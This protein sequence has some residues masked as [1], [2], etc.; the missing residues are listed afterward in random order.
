MTLK[1]YGY[2]GCTTVNRAVAWAKNAG[3]DPDYSHFAKVN[4]LKDHI[5]SWIEIAGI[6]AVFNEKAQTFKKMDAAE[7][8]AITQSTQTRIAAM[9]AE[10]RLIKR[11]VGTDGRS[12]LTG[13]SEDQWSSVF[14]K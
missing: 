7:R 10:P 11:P 13:F 8:E 1:I 12:V 3:L 2:A 14:G 9:A 5:A 4:E 6:D